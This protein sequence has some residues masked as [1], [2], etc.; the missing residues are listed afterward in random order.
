MTFKR[1]KFGKQGEEAAVSFLKKK[2]YRILQKNFRCSLGEIDIIAEHHRAVVFVEVKSR[3]G[4]EF[5]HPVEA[6]T[7]IKRNKISRVA[8]VF[9]SRHNLQ[10]RDLRFDVVTVAGDPG[11][12]ETW[13]VEVIKDA[14]R[15]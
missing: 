14:F 5:G 7:A 12:P 1:Q 11:S 8:Q 4:E 6:I 13:E 15:M 3:T 9:S 10:N 2:G